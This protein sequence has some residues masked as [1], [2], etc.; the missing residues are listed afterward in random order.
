MAHP[1]CRQCVLGLE[2]AED[3]VGERIERR[4]VPQRRGAAVARQLRQ[5]HA[6]IGRE[7][8]CDLPPVRREA[9]ETVD[10]RDGRTL[11]ADEVADLR[12][13]RGK[14]P[15]LESGQLPFGLRLHL[16]IFFP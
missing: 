5:D 11:A 4:G 6:P 16:G 8:G 15:F 14:P 2:D 3:R 13:S 12:V 1:R 9:A 10:E 7:L